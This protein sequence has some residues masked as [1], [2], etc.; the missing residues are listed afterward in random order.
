MVSKRPNLQSGY[1]AKC[2]R[3]QRTIY[4]AK[5]VRPDK[6]FALAISALMVCIPAFSFPLISVHLL[7]I[8]EGT[9]LIHGAIMMIDIAPLVSFMVLFCAVLSPTL[10]T[11]CMAF[12][13]FCMMYN[14]RPA[15]L[16][17]VLKLTSALLHW[18]MLEVYLISLMVAIVK[19]MSYADLYYGSG[20]LFFIALLIINMTMIS[21]YNNVKYWEY[22]R[23]G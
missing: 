15:M 9:N 19:L 13:S 1:V 11:L 10:L 4:T 17:Y 21:E 12:S 7:G 6:M 22:L 2:A 5:V 8:T 18:S 14:K 20:M 3:C 23:N 16:N